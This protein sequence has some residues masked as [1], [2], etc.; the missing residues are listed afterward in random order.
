MSQI[1]AVA[2]PFLLVL[3]ILPVAP[4]IEHIVR[5]HFVSAPTTSS[6]PTSTLPIRPATNIPTTTAPLTTTTGVVPTTTTSVAPSPSATNSTGADGARTTTPS[7]VVTSGFHG[8][9]T[10][11]DALAQSS[12]GG[13]TSWVLW[14]AAPVT[15]SLACGSATT[16][17]TAEDVTVSPADEGCDLDV[18]LDSP[19]TVAWRITPY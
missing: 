16:A 3:L 7:T 14:S 2:V 4:R 8:T 15:W 17:I 12:V 11:E 5:T 13:G 6:I 1:I 19:G 9:L 18:Q 10:T